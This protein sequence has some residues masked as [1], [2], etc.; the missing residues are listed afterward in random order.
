ML[1][2]KRKFTASE[3]E[4]FGGASASASASGSTSASENN[5]NS[6][7]PPPANYSRRQDGTAEDEEAAQGA[8]DL[9]RPK[10]R[11]PQKQE[12]EVTARTATDEAAAQ[13]N[14]GTV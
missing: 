9:S 12:V 5:G 7:H 8:V 14:K 13:S 10:Q 3:F 2:K 1:P 11:P 6:D 4:T